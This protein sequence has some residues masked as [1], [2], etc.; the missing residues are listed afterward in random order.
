[1]WARIVEAAAPGLLCEGRCRAQDSGEDR[2][3]QERFV[4][5]AV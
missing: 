2:E 5:G 1:M 3:E 4:G